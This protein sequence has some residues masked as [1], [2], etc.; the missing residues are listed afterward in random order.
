[1]TQS[2]LLDP[3]A[4]DPSWLVLDVRGEGE[5]GQGHWSGAARVPVSD[6]E[7]AAK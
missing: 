6:W 2:A 7:A 4:R 3:S 1:M 5:Y